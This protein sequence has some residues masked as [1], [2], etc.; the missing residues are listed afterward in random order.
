M[1]SPRQRDHATVQ[2]EHDC[3][4]LYGCGDFGLL[5]QALSDV[6]PVRSI[7]ARSQDQIHILTARGHNI[8]PR[9]IELA[10][11]CD[12]DVI[13]AAVLRAPADLEPQPIPNGHHASR[14]KEQI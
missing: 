3:V 6:K 13:I 9:L 5:A 1:T 8:L 7:I 14:S 2:P 10:E 12:I 11:A 4:V